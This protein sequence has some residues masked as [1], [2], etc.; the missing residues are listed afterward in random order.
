[1]VKGF[2]VIQQW[3][4]QQLHRFRHSLLLFTMATILVL[5]LTTKDI[6]NLVPVVVMLI[7]FGIVWAGITGF[8]FESDKRAPESTKTVE[9]EE[10]WLD[11]S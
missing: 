3:V 10:E 4:A 11:D 1:M 9:A 6:G 2:L 5:V 8:N 7:V